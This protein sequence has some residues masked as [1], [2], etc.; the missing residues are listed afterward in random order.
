MYLCMLDEKDFQEKP[1]RIRHL[2]RRM[3]HCCETRF[4]SRR[5][6]K[7]RILFEK[8]EEAKFVI[9]PNTPVREIWSRAFH[10]FQARWKRVAQRFHP[11]KTGEDLRA[12]MSRSSPS[13]L[14][15]SHIM[16]VKQVSF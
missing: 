12:V 10:Q 14:E 4:E 5:I 9:S 13:N 2:K 6:R 11:R 15:H 3:P 7:T 1:S 16:K 8:P